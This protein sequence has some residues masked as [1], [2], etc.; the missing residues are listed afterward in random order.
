MEA[1]GLVV[2]PGGERFALEFFA[3]FFALNVLLDSFAH[4]PVGRAAAGGGEALDAV[5]GCGIK[6]EAGGGAGHGETRCYLVSLYHEERSGR[7]L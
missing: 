6:L 1:G 4:D 5:F 7:L 2:L 3:F